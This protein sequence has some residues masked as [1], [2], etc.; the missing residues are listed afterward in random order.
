MRALGINFFRVLI[1]NILITSA[2]SSLFS[3]VPFR[4]DEVLR[5]PSGF[6]E[7]ICIL[8]QRDNLANGDSDME[9]KRGDVDKRNCWDIG[10]MYPSL[11]AWYERLKEKTGD[12]RFDELISYKGQLHVSPEILRRGLD[13]YFDLG[14]A[15]E[16]FLVYARLAFDEDLGSD[17]TKEAYG[18]I[19][20]IF[21][22]FR[23]KTSWIEPEILQIS[24]D[25]L[26]KY[27]EDGELKKY[28]FY[29]KKLLRLKP[30]TLNVGEEE[31]L[32]R[33]SQTFQTPYKTFSS[34]NNA[35][36]VFGNVKDS[37]GREHKLS[38]G[39]YMIF[40]R[41]PDRELRRSSFKSLHR[42]FLE[43]ENTLC[44]LIQG[45]IKN[46]VF[47]AKT[48]GF[49]NCLE[50]ALYPDNIDL[51]VYYNLIKSVRSRI[52]VLH[53][54]VRMKK[55]VLGLKDIHPYDLYA[56]LVRDVD[57]K[58]GIEEAKSMV[59]DSVSSLSKEY[60]DILRKGLFKDRW[61]DFF[62][63]ERK[64]S[65]AYSS[66]CYDSMP[67]I[68]MNYHGSLNDLLTL[69]HEA[70][71]SMHSFLS[72]SNQPYHLAEYPIF[73]AE[74]ASTFNEQL[75]FDLLSK[76]E[77]KKKKAALLGNKIDAIHATF[78]RQTLFA[79]FE[80]MLHEI[81]ESGKPLTP[82]VLKKIYR[83]LYSDYYGEDL[84]L[85]DEIEIEWARVPHFYYNYYVYQYATGLSAA[86]L[87][88]DSI[89]N[90]RCSAEDY[91][92]FLKAGGSE[93]PLDLLKKAGVDLK[94]KGSVESL[95]NY[96]DSLI[97]KLEEIL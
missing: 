91:L 65:G 82:G 92:A 93:Y 83:K 63:T 36:I 94:R 72:N 60:Q 55:K 74:V 25:K 31:I 26:K 8:W 96:F 40:L 48:R 54:F 62:E 45:Q 68:L 71:H 1:K 56:P 4:G 34:F 77:D 85:D 23:E 97:D 22:N 57:F 39:K 66:G 10:R 46:H 5:R 87:L 27:V 9:L 3:S 89:K 32:A 42:R 73:V 58:V 29:L 41:S 76:T 44:E 38:H 30:Y 28:S 37:K 84:I 75:L 81:V 12:T 53:K 18:L 21:F 67:Y 64:R 11:D 17:K 90:K 35:D 80:L 52:D 86:I 49:K 43:F 16:N 14:R 95:I 61:V 19:S 6:F 20:T 59:V 15:F 51:E 24:S 69:A 70:G 33:V 50:A 47:V 78:F 88:F 2:F 79:E 13:Y 7:D